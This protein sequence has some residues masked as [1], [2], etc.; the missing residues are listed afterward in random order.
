VRDRYRKNDKPPLSSLT[1]PPF[2]E[3]TSEGL[4]LSLWIQPGAKKTGW[5]GTHGKQLKLTVQAP[6]VENA[7]NQSCLI[8]LAKVFG[9][10]KADILLLKGGKS[11]SKL[12]LIKGLELEK[13]LF[14][15]PDRN[16]DLQ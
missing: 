10:K 12:F 13:C 7:A 14:L 16:P 3:P 4:L 2:L 1:L 11:R 15:I 9:V 5:A 8:F 6:P